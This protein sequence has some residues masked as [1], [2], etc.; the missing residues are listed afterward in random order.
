MNRIKK[1]LL[2]WFLFKVFLFRLWLQ[3][4]KIKNKL[5]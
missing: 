5:H 2:N 4:I 3:R 1:K